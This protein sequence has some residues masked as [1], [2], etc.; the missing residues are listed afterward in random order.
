[1]IS[2]AQT[3]NT[4]ID[5]H[6]AWRLRVCLKCKLRPEADARRL[7]QEGNEL[8]AIVTAIIRHKRRNMAKKLA[9]KISRTARRP[10]ARWNLECV[11]A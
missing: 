1:M 7:V 6:M 2:S 8:I 5:L 3:S 4:T 10:P 9:A 11:T